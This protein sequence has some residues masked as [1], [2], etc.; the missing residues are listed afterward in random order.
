MD[1]GRDVILD[2][3]LWNPARRR[4]WVTKIERAGHRYTLFYF[5]VSFETLKERL[6][7]RNEEPDPGRV[8]A[9]PLA[10]V[11]RFATQFFQ[12]PTP[13]EGLNVQVISHPR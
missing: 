10:E 6:R 13:D 5:D 9:I 12:P 1:Q 2:W 3:S 8:H 7:A 11:E 4:A